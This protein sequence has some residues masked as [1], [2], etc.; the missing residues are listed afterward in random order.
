MK[1]P[2]PVIVSIAAA[3]G[4][5]AI[6]A[7]RQPS[8]DSPTASEPYSDVAAAD[9]AIRHP[10][11]SLERIAQGSPV[12]PAKLPT[13]P[14]AS[15]DDS[16]IRTWIESELAALENEID[17]PKVRSLGEAAAQAAASADTKDA[18]YNASEDVITYAYESDDPADHRK[19]LYILLKA[20]TSG[21]D[22]PFTFIRIGAYLENRGTA[23]DLRLAMDAYR[24]AADRD[25]LPAIVNFAYIAQHEPE[26]R[27]SELEAYLRY[28]FDLDADDGGWH[29]LSYLNNFYLD[30]YPDRA[31][32]GYLTRLV[33]R[34]RQFG[35]EEAAASVNYRM[36]DLGKER[37]PDPKAELAAAKEALAAGNY[38][39]MA[40][41]GRAYQL[42]LGTEYDRDL[43]R[44]YLAE[45][46]LN[47]GPDPFCALN[48]GSLYTA[49]SRDSVD[50]PLA[51]AIYKYAAEIGASDPS[52]IGAKARREF[53]DRMPDLTPDEIAL[54][55]RYY[56]AIAEGD[57]SGIPHLKD[58][59]PV[60]E[61]AQQPN[62]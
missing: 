3:V 43:A 23:E 24:I 27:P 40:T 13:T 47:Y 42:G 60:P 12:D 54:M 20:A 45:C 49:Y 18:F 53:S 38:W 1:I 62:E 51:V 32:D 15:W 59:R 56:Q 55:D 29:I 19:G 10:D 35:D 57:Y 21:R 16:A 48:L 31:S 41:I 28:G 9:L 26:I 25:F 4:I 8:G 5:I 2:V 44:D 14:I 46:M 22:E 37:E 33:E 52:D 30:D 7:L 36:Y 34:Y 50:P 6:F 58:A 61:L 39:I 11:P 17:D